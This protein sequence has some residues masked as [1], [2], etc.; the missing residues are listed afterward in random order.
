[1]LDAVKRHFKVVRAIG[2][3]KVDRGW[4][5]E[6]AIRDDY[7][8]HRVL[9]YADQ[10]RIGRPSR[11]RPPGKEKAAKGSTLPIERDYLKVMFDYIAEHRFKKALDDF[12]DTQ[13]RKLDVSKDVEAAMGEGYKLRPGQIVE[14]GGKKIK[15]FQFDPGNY[16]YPEI[17]EIDKAVNHGIKQAM[18]ANDTLA[19]NAVL[20]ETEERPPLEDID[21][22]GEP[23]FRKRLIIGRKKPTYALPLNVAQRLEKFNGA[24]NNSDFV[25]A[26]NK[27]TGKWKG[28]TI[29]FGGVSFQVMNM[30]GDIG[31][32][33]R[34]DLGSIGYLPK[35]ARML[36]RK[37]VDAKLLIKLAD[38][39]EVVAS[40][41]IGSEV[42]RLL[43]TPEFRRFNSTWKNLKDSPGL[44]A[45]RVLAASEY[46]ENIPRLALFLANVARLKGGEKA[47][48]E[49]LKKVPVGERLVPEA[50]KIPAAR[51]L[52]TGE[53]N[54]E[55]LPP[56]LG[57][58]KAA[59]EIPVDYRKF[60][61]DE[62]RYLRGMFLPFYA[63][64]KQNASGWAR[65]AWKHP[66]KFTGLV[67]APWMMMEL[68]TP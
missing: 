55:G 1:V 28:L 10:N 39:L 56:V 29:N 18:Q 46:R 48:I 27:T 49:A 15:G 12:I 66:W 23:E 30:L 50:E 52:K 34:A 68:W 35:A 7:F 67:L 65:F 33:S 40:G 31:N 44:L 64:A 43:E 32:I 17:T 24:N 13:S 2:E 3:E 60:T 61:D 42:T 58:A 25:R 57:A 19:A 45:D 6:D 37:D 59:R 63:W 20:G 22:L 26:I 53:V 54:I 16:I 4:M 9:M 21:E 14:I 8:R 36:L 41:F 11:I 62:N 51:P 38:E 47:L 5:A